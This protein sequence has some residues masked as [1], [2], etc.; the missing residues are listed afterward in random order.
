MKQLFRRTLF[1]VVIKLGREKNVSS[2][3]GQTIAERNNISSAAAHSRLEYIS[4]VCDEIQRTCHMRVHK[5][6]GSRYA[7]RQKGF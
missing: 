1:G 7:E 2:V 4:V 5:S 6:Y 3:A